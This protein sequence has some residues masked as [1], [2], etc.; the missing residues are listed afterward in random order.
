LGNAVAA[1]LS[2]V[3]FYD[4]FYDGQ[5]KAAAS[6]M[7]RCA[8]LLHHVGAVEDTRQMLFCNSDSI[9]FYVNNKIFSRKICSQRDPGRFF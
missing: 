1:D 2:V 5:P 7:I 8:A 6:L 4:R 9:V 3:P